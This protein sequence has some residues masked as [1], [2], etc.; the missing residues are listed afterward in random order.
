MR[1]AFR[2][3]IGEGVLDNFRKFLTPAFDLCRDSLPKLVLV[4]NHN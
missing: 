3:P 2:R 4:P 1:E